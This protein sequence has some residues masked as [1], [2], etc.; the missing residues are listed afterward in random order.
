MALTWATAAWFLPFV[1]PIAIWVAWSDMA[2][3]KIPN[4]AVLAMLIVFVVI[5]LLALPLDEYLWRYAHFG[6]VL[7]IGFLLNMV[8]AIGAGDAKFAAAM[9]PFIERGDAFLFM[10]ILAATTFAAFVVHRVVR[11]TSLKE[12]FAEV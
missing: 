6:V 12:R 7:V 1:T 11:A 10:I 3:M 4:K 8:R 2:T 9:A 5:G